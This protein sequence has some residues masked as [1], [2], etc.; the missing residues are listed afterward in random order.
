[1]TG[2]AEFITARIFEDEA[3]ASA[4]ADAD[5][6][7]WDDLKGDGTHFALHD[8]ARVLRQA[9]AMREILRAYDD[10]LTFGRGERG[11]VTRTLEKVL[12]NLASIWSDHPDYDRSPA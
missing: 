7:F 3:E 4:T 6:E 10:A 5:A 9:A 1:M 12:A 11:Y 8:P 2:W